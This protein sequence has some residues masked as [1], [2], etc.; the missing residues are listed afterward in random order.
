M[1]WFQDLPVH[2]TIASFVLLIDIIMFILAARSRYYDLTH[3]SPFDKLESSEAS[4]WIILV[5]WFLMIPL[6]WI[7]FLTNRF[8]YLCSFIPVLF[9]RLGLMIAYPLRMTPR[10][11]WE[12]I[13]LQTPE[14]LTIV[15]IAVTAQIM[16]HVR[17]RRN[18]REALTRGSVVYQQVDHT[19]A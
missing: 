5:L 3:S 1:K 18:D 16:E 11:R 12:M 13:L 8:R 19:R 15:L 6:G 10:D 14:L 17:K 9:L 4:K 7:A 2:R